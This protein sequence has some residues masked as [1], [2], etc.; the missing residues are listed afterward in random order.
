[1]SLQCRCDLKECIGGLVYHVKRQNSVNSA[2]TSI[3][4]PV[5]LRKHQVK[6]NIKK[7]TKEYIVKQYYVNETIDNIDAFYALPMHSHCIANALTII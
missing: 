6:S 7:H 3:I 5:D 2:M 1:M 4:V